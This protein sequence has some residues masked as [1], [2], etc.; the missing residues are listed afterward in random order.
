MF[1]KLNDRRNQILV[2][3]LIIFLIMTYR[4]ANLTII[5]GEEYREKA[6]NNRLRKINEVAKRG[7]IYDVNGTLLAGSIPG[8]IVNLNGSIVSKDDLNEVAV[9]IIDILDEKDE[10]HIEFPIRIENGEFYYSYD[11]ELAKWLTENNFSNDD[12]AEDV[13]EEIKRREQIFFEIDPYEA[14]KLLLLK[15]VSM[16]I[17]ISKMKFRAVINK[18]N[19][20]FILWIAFRYKCRRSI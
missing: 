12:S 17:S 5:N 13:F 14:Q 7:D 6:I 16:P 1:F 3:F 8:F 18:E 11:R 10:K 2:F 4:L 19:F 15:G 9:K 20:L